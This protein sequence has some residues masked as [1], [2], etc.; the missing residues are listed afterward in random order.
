MIDALALPL[1][2]D[3]A[4]GVLCLVGG[5]A[6]F[7]LQDLILKLL[8]GNYPLHQAMLLRSLAAIPFLLALVWFEGGFRALAT[9]GWRVLFLRG[10]IMFSAYTSYYLALAALPMATTVALYFAAPLFITVLSILFLAESVGPRRWIAVIA[11]FAGVVIMVRPGSALFDWAALL[12]VYAGLAYALSMIIARRQGSRDGAA[13]MAFYGNGV[14][15]AC[16]VLLSLVFGSGAFA[17]E[18]HKSLGFLLRGWVTPTPFDLALMVSCGVIAAIGLTL[19]TQAYRIA[20]ANVVAPFEYSAL[21]WS[22]LYGWLIWRDWPDAVGWL[23]IGIIVA[24]GLYV[25]YREGR[26][27]AS[28]PKSESIFGRH[29]AAD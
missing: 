21:L 7:S 29:D 20:E 14:F 1:R 15:L 25:L 22:V 19:L 11:G 8:S 24:A 6:V 17:S 26:A 28:A 4:K 10:L 5:I 9:P 18:A 27:T 12:P 23:G 16:A 3:T 13:V 2:R